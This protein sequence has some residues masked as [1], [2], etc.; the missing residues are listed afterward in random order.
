[1]SHD[2]GVEL[3]NVVSNFIDAARLRVI[4]HATNAGET[5]DA[6][7]KIETGEEAVF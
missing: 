3:R 4:T 2:G 5:N 7:D 6:A 1:M